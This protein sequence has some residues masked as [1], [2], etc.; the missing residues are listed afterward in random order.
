MSGLFDNQPITISTSMAVPAVLTNQAERNKAESKLAALSA[1]DR[2]HVMQLKNSLVPTDFSSINKFADSVAG[3]GGQIV[4]SMLKQVQADKLSGV[5]G[6][7]NSILMQAKNINSND[8]RN[9]KSGWLTR[10]FPFIFTTKE[11]VL[12]RFASAATQIER[13]STEIRKSMDQT[14]VDIRTM[15]QMGQNCVKQYNQYEAMIAAGELQLFDLRDDVARESA[16]LGQ[17]PPE[18]VD[19]LRT[20][21]LQK[22]VD[23]CDTLDK[24]ISNLRQIQQ[25]V[26]IQIPQLGLMI[27][28]N[29]DIANEFRTILDQTIPL[30]KTLFAQEIM[31]DTQAKNVQIIQGAKD[32]TNDQLVRISENLK[33]TTLAIGKQNARGMIDPETIKTVQDNFCQ[34]L[35]GTLEQYRIAREN[36]QKL[37]QDIDQMRID[38]K[39]NL[40]NASSGTASLTYTK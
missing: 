19:P 40:Q 21:Q 10:V 28:N 16:E 9:A 33:N 8:L 35:T 34:T 11:K 20:Q 1:S 38:F 14:E 31:L 17:L 36:R 2:A 26:Y 37:A 29:V 15:E 3:Q 30:W 24:K 27:K 7:I 18:Q 32:F 6:G 13:T 5:S 39:Q 22:K 12:A 23:F 4:D 25:V